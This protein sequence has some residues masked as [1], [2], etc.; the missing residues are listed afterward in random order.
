MIRFVEHCEVVRELL[1]LVCFVLFCFAMLT[2]VFVLCS[3]AFNASQEPGSNQMQL[4]KDSVVAVVDQDDDAGWFGY[5]Q[6]GPTTTVS[7]RF[8]AG[9]HVALLPQ[10]EE[11]VSCFFA[12]AKYDYKVS[13]QRSMCDAAFV[14][15]PN[16]SLSSS[17]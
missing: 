8:P 7:G 13:S 11:G 1:C 3:R 9:R 2:A 17:L 6:D 10:L 5:R 12:L 14:R 16:F 15:V 4:I